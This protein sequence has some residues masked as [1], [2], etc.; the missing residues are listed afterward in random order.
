MKYFQVVR[1][2]KIAKEILG[3][4]FPIETEHLEN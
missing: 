2:T 1:N 3:L 4:I